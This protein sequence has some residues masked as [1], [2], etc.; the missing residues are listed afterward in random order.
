MDICRVFIKNLLKIVRSR[1]L[2]VGDIEKEADMSPGY[3]SRLNRSNN[4][5]SLETAYK[6]SNIVGVTIDELLDTESEL[7]NRKLTLEKEL[8]EI[9]EKLNKIDMS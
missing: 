6:L 4:A 3:I 1:G 9:Q 2:R 8:A 7:K 5:F